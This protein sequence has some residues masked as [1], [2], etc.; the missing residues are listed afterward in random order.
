M[1]ARRAFSRPRFQTGRAGSDLARPGRAC[2]RSTGLVLTAGGGPRWSSS[3]SPS[4]RWA[5]EADAGTV[6]RGAVRLIRRLSVRR[7]PRLAGTSAAWSADTAARLGRA[8]VDAVGY[9]QGLVTGVVTGS[10]YR[11]RN[12]TV[13]TTCPVAVARTGTNGVS[14][15]VS[16]AD[17]VFAVQLPWVICKEPF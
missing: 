16:P 13:Q 4:T 9:G 14:M 7:R 1:R 2:R 8:T 6:P 12:V 11:T 5:T 10:S 3:P 17:T 15:E